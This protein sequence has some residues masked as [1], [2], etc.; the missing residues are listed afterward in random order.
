MTRFEH[1]LS[2][3]VFGIKYT[4][5]E[6]GEGL[7]RHSHDAVTAHNV[8]VLRGKV[9][10]LFDDEVKQLGA[11]DIYDFDGGR[12]HSIM[13]LTA[14]A[15]ILNLF[16]N[17]RPVEYEGLPAHELKGEFSIQDVERS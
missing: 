7:P 6:A 8:C 13:A 9:S 11:G 1:Y 10:V 2:G 4:F 3:N 17:G 16:L 5:D 15:C 12:P 14:N